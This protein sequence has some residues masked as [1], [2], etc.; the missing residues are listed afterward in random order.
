MFANLV[1][2]ADVQVTPLAGEAL[3]ERIGAQ[4]AAQGNLVCLAQRRPTLD[5]NIG[6][7]DTTRPDDDIRLDDAKVA[8]DGLR[9]NH[10]A[11]VDARRRCDGGGR[12]NGHNFV[13]YKYAGDGFRGM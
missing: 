6:L 11:G 2:V 4:G 1:A 10:R 13:S 9:A 5:V 7:Q 12:I 8:D 3:V